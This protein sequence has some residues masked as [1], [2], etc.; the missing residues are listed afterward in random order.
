MIQRRLLNR[1]F[2][3][4][5]SSSLKNTAVTNLI[6]NNT[7]INLQK[8]ANPINVS[9]FDLTA[10]I[11]ELMQDFTNASVLDRIRMINDLHGDKAIQI[12]SMQNKW[13]NNAFII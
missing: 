1:Y 10:K 6:L 8:F 9:A 4:Y 3:N 12:A 5:A 11:L 13:C 2:N 7:S